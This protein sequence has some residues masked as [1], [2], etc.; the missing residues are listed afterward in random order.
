MTS[1][2]NR[3]SMKSK[4]IKRTPKNNNTMMCQHED[5]SRCNS[6]LDSAPDTNTSKQKS[7]QLI[8]HKPSATQCTLMPLHLEW[9]QVHYCCYQQLSAATCPHF[10]CGMCCFSPHFTTF[11]TAT[12]PIQ[13]CGHHKNFMYQHTDNNKTVTQQHKLNCNQSNHTLEHR[14]NL[15]QQHP[16]TH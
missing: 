4:N 10:I 15:M 9:V 13:L 3:A 14:N 16:A 5:Q 12:L 2:E 8:L 11:T 6:Q 7:P 1:S